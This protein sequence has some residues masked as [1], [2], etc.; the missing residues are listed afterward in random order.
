MSTRGLLAFLLFY[1]EHSRVKAEKDKGL[2]LLQGL[3]VLTLKPDRASQVLGMAPEPAELER[4]TSLV[5][6]TCPHYLASVS[7]ISTSEHPHWHTALLLHRGFECRGCACVATWLQRCLGEVVLAVNTEL[8]GAGYTTDP[9]KAIARP[10]KKRR[11]IDEDYKTL[12][13]VEAVQSGRASS[14]AS[15]ARAQGDFHDTNVY[16]WMQSDLLKYQS[17]CWHSVSGRKGMSVTVAHD[18]GRFGNPA[19][20]HFAECGNNNRQ[21]CR[22]GLVHVVALSEGVSVQSYE[23]TDKCFCRCRINVFLSFLVLEEQSVSGCSGPQAPEKEIDL[24]SKP[25]LCLFAFVNVYPQILPDWIGAPAGSTPGVDGEENP[26]TVSAQLDA[27]VKK[28]LNA[29]E[30]LKRKKLLAKTPRSHNKAHLLAV[31]NALRAG[32]NMSL[33]SFVPPRPVEMLSGA[34]RRRYIDVSEATSALT[35][36]ESYTKRACVEDDSGG[37]RYYEVTRKYNSKSGDL[38]M[39]SIHMV[40]DKGPK[41]WSALQFLYESVHVRGFLVADPWHQDWNGVRASISEVGLL[42]I[43][44]E[45]VLV[46]N[47]PSG[48]FEGSSAFQSLKLAGEELLSQSTPNTEFF[49]FFLD[50]LS[51]SFGDYCC[52]DFGSTEHRARIWQKVVDSKV[53]RHKTPSV[54]MGRWFDVFHKYEDIPQGYDE[55]VRMVLVYYGMKEGW[56]NSIWDSPVCGGGSHI[57]ESSRVQVGVGSESGAG[58]AGSASGVQKSTVS[59]SNRELQQLRQD[60][61]NTKEVVLRILSDPW[62]QR[63]WQ[64]MRYVMR[65]FLHSFGKWQVMSKTGKGNVELHIEWASGAIHIVSSAALSRIHGGEGFESLR[66]RTTAVK[67][68][69][70]VA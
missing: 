41:C 4:C 65:P 23:Y 55:I 38:I 60:S 20:G 1:T 44:L 67:G 10:G 68:G 45:R 28:G 56:F 16:K 12:T 35:K 39:P 64:A 22:R 14:A 18:A 19:R 13:T 30:T 9:S 57:T 21:L 29:E 25:K 17:K 27:F 26:G 59:G 63:L 46:S 62:K 24:Q 32:M 51:I 43:L 54:R 48:P 36:E 7:G 33:A 52:T 3:L 49:D 8:Q 11:L 66:F 31:D 34:K 47:M 42:T 15:F 5:D 40:S 53:L 50:E 58:A 70:A 2:A 69:D 61:R 37:P 6:G